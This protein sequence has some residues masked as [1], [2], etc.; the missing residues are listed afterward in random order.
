MGGGV[1]VAK[2]AGNFCVE[3]KNIFKNIW[4]QAFILLG[5]FLA[6][7]RY[8][9]GWDDQALEIPLLKSLIDPTLFAGDYYVEALKGSF[10]SYFYIRLS[11]VVTVTRIPNVS[12]GLYLLSRYFF[13][14]FCKT[15]KY[16]Q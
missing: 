3:I 9:Y 2:F 5:F 6:T 14:F 8:I 4:V 1:H 12:F 10:T 11:K 13:F 7:N 15:T 16:R